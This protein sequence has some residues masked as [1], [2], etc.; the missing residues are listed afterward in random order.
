MA[1]RVLIVEDSPLMQRLLSAILGAEDDIKVAGIAV[2]PIEAR[3]KI[4]QL[5]PDV[6]TLDVEMPRMDG[7]TFLGRLMRLRPMPVVMVSALTEGNAEV[8]L[9]AL[10][11]GAVDFVTKPSGEA[12]RD[13]HAFGADLVEKV[14]EA[15]LAE[16]RVPGAAVAIAAGT[17]VAFRPGA[18]IAVGGSTGATERIRE[19]LTRLP[20]NAPPVAIV[21]HMPEM[22]TTLFARRLDDLCA[23][24]VTEAADGEV[25]QSGH[26]YIA[27]GDWHLRVEAKGADYVARIGQDPP[28]NRHRPSVDA[29]FQSAARAAGARAAGVLLTGMGRDGA[30]GLGAL[31]RSGGAT[32]AQDQASCVVFG[33]PRAAIEA[34]YAGH[35]DRVEGIAARLIE[36]LRR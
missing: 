1:I 26:A 9:R 2:D 11:L 17:P 29:L 23:L 8:T 32:F 25:L 18:L 19:L 14:R 24:K 10:E 35:V 7:I 36:A 31:M 21:Q 5:K 34:G 16:V 20:E 13:L 33:M 30:E 4:K 12:A 27:P 22:F 15:A 28:V 3:E 6:I